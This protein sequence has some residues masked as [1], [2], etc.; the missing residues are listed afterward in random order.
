MTLRGWLKKNTSDVSHLSEKFTFN[1]IWLMQLFSGVF[2][3]WKQ[4]M[5]WPFNHINTILVSLT[6]FNLCAIFDHSNF[7]RTNNKVMNLAVSAQKDIILRQREGRSIFSIHNNLHPA[8]AHTLI[9]HIMRPNSPNGIF[10][11]LTKT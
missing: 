7:M 4:H 2:I 6:L 8:T 1:I 5:M 11:R 10:L 9:N 3:F